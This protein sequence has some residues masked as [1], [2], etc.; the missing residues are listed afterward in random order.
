MDALSHVVV[1]FPRLK[2]LHLSDVFFQRVEHLSKLLL[3]CPILEDLNIKTLRPFIL[4]RL[5]LEEN[6]Q[7]L[8][9]LIRANISN[10]H[11]RPQS[12]LFTL[13]C[14]AEVLHAEL[15]VL[16]Y[17]NKLTM[18]HN[19]TYLEIILKNNEGAKWKWMLDMLKH[20]PKLQ[21]LTIHEVLF[22]SM[23]FYFFLL[24]HF[25]LLELIKNYV[26]C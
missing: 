17:W 2:T 13:C 10:V 7:C 8:T 15:E 3:G 20:C 5:V 12:D 18:Y 1:D 25:S 19:L 9:N 16:S 14:K 24:E 11:Y 21:N 26:N 22:M 23:N 6:I 4:E